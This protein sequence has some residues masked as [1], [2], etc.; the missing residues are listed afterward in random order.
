MRKALLLIFSTVIALNITFAQKAKIVPEA[1][2]P[3]KLIK[4]GLTTTPNSVYS[5]LRI[6]GNGTYIYLSAKNIGNTSPVTSATWSFVS[7]PGTSTADFTQMSN[8]IVYFKADQKGTYEVKVHMVTETGSHDTTAKFYSADYFGS[9]DFDGVSSGFSCM[10][11]H[12]SSSKF[13]DIYNRWKTSGHANIFKTEITSGAAYYGTSCMKCH[14]VGYDHNVAANNGGFDDVA[15]NLGWNWSN[16]APPKADNW[17]TLKT[18]Y[19]GLVKYA[20]VGCENCHGP[21]GEHVFG[22]TPKKESIQISIADGACAQCHDEPWRHNKVSEYENSTHSEAIWSNSFAQSSGQDNSLGNCIRCHDGQGYVNFTKGLTTNTTGMKQANHISITCATCHDPHGNTNTASLRKSP[23]AS[24]TLG[25][26]YVY[27]EGG[28]GKICMDCHKSRRNVNTYVNTT[29]S[30]TWG[31]HHSTQTD[32]FLGKGAAAFGTAYNSGNHKYAVVDGCVGCHMT[33]TTDTGTVTRDRVGGHSWKLAD[34]EH[35]YDHTKGCASCHGNKNSFADFKSAYD[36]DGDG[37]I[38]G[39]QGEVKGLL[40]HLRMALPPVGK[41]SVSW[42][43]IKASNNLNI[44]KAYYN[45]Q[46]I[47]YDGSYGMH[48]FQFAVDVIKKSLDALG[49]A[50]PVELISLNAA[51]Q[52]NEIVVNWTTASEKNNKG[53]E[54][55]RKSGDN[56]IKV[57]FVAG[58]GTTT[59]VSRYSWVDNLKG[60]ASG[61]I[62]YRLKQIDLDGTVHYSKTTEVNYT[63]GPKEYTLSQNYPNPFNPS[64]QINFSLP[65]AEN[66]SVVVYDA[67]GN[68]IATLVS[69]KMEA[70]NHTVTWNASAMPSGVYFYKLSSGNFSSVKKMIL[71]K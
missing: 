8:G 32:V 12:S 63:S 40:K 30:S 41:D 20:N 29:V 57:A 19:P 36:Y 59:E 66:V 21:A 5:G 34:E 26:G 4:L 9:P 24:D 65:Q 1:I 25:S 49:Y 23:A 38:E 37:V 47:E 28:T 56:W 17:N 45:Y 54:I 52:N 58:K 60:V 44:K 13:A 50:V 69:G 70:G 2:T 15:A 43:D 46:L 61:K 39:V 35:S 51:L 18:T 64:T 48:N 68:E 11:C 71:M 67:I 6:V 7:K 16:Y 55:E 33:A 53:F 27:T 62:S 3:E 14:T 22:S 10:S 42:S 31:P